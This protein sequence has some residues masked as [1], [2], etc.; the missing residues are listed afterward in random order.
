MQEF[1]LFCALIATADV[2]V[3]LF[4]TDDLL[5][6]DDVGGLD[7]VGFT[8]SGAIV[9]A[10]LFAQPKVVPRTSA[11]IKTRSCVFLQKRGIRF[12]V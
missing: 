5:A 12:S 9:W 1:F 6:T 7:V 3:V 4:D 10:C 11:A 8:A 2:V